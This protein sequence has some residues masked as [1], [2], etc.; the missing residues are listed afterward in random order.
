MNVQRMTELAAILK[1]DTE[2]YNTVGYNFAVVIDYTR[3]PEAKIGPAESRVTIEEFRVALA[4]GEIQ[5]VTGCNAAWACLIWGESAQPLNVDTA[6]LLLE[7]DHQ[8]TR[9]L[10]HN[11][12]HFVSYTHEWENITR[13]QSA[14]AI[15]KMI[16]EDTEAEV[17]Q[18]ELDEAEDRDEDEYAE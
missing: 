15:W 12:E 14:Q 16:G 13:E 9:Q 8:Q 17:N 10:F 11:Q 18:A 5:D 3:K 6:Q 1:Q 7:L 4:K 2:L